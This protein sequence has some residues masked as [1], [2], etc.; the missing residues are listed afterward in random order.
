MA[1]Q[2]T[3][4]NS[5]NWTS[6]AKLSSC[7]L[8]IVLYLFCALLCCACRY[9][10]FIFVSF[11]CLRLCYAQSCSF[12]WQSC[13]CNCSMF[14]MFRHSGSLQMSSICPVLSLTWELDWPFSS[15]SQVHPGKLDIW[16]GRAVC[17]LTI[18]EQMMYNFNWVN[19]Y[20]GS[21]CVQQWS[22]KSHDGYILY[23]P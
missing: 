15:R 8:Y 14:F 6:P 23:R 10:V 17:A 2:S 12:W 16:S 4:C 1:A 19:L 7:T 21:Q 9:A 18:S 3:L 20:S 13:A 5:C 11:R 22:W